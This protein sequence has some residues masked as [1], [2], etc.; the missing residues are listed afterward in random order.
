M[1][2]IFLRKNR[3]FTIVELLVVVVILGL[4]TAI[5]I[6]T[7]RNVVLYTERKIVENNLRMIDAAIAVYYESGNTDSLQGLNTEDLFKKLVPNFLHAEIS[8]PGTARYRT[9]DHI[10]TPN[11]YPQAQV[12]STDKAG[13]HEMG[14]KQYYTIDKLPWYFE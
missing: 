11:G 4:L 5:G 3:G 2:R 1:F 8:G 9:S 12:I 14:L 10:N 7:Y 6:P 13:G